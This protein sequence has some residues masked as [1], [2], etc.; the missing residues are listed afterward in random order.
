M[1]M[2]HR[3][4]IR[5]FM[6]TLIWCC[7]AFLNSSVMADESR[8]VYGETSRL[9]SFDPYTTHELAAQRLSDLIFD[10]LISY[11]PC[12]EYKAGLAESWEVK[13]GN[14]AILFKLRPGVKWHDNKT[15][16]PHVF[17]AADVIAT[18]KVITNSKSEIPNK[19]RFEVIDQVSSPSPNEVLVTLKRANV[20]PLRYFTFRILPAHHISGSDGLTRNSFLT[21]NPIGTG[22]Y[23][24]VKASAQG[25]VL[26]TANSDYF[27]GPPSIK[28]IIMKNYSDQSIMAQ[29]LMFNSLDLVTYVSP[30]DLDEIVADKRLKVTP[31]DA[32]SYSFFAHNTERPLLKDK[33]VRQAISYAINREE[34]LNSFFG[35]KGEL[36][37]GPFPPTSWAYNLSVKNIEYNQATAKKLL[38]E[39]GFLDRDKNGFLEDASGKELRLQLAVPV[40]GESETIKRIVLAFQ[41]YLADV[42]IAVELQFL[43]WLVWK[44]RILGRHDFDITVATWAFDDDSNITTLFHSS[45]AKPWG[46]NFVSFKNGEVDALLT[47]AEL[48]ADYERKRHI[49]QK[50]H[51]ILAD[52]APYT[53]L[54]TLKH[55]AA[56]TQALRGVSIEPFAFFQDIYKWKLQ[57]KKL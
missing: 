21:K 17:T 12:G 2:K 23:R 10:S 4:M 14:S 27:A 22:P 56:H 40:N 7:G 19:E 16:N 11:L 6:T 45:N 43:D 57:D 42:G 9:D 54:W 31:Y 36:I 46:N 55:H 24:F 20:D 38:A 34:M 53:F 44:D 26:L 47:E 35:G 33:R 5:K 50:L 8:M 25:E 29:S 30:R 32:L 39:A 51:A 28:E 13:K 48:S 18:I 15:E 41:S 49:Y 37:S 1:L 3:P 52:E